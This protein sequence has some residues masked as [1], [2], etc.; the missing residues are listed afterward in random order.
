HLQRIQSTRR[1]V[2][3]IFHLTENSHLFRV[4]TVPLLPHVEGS[5]QWPEKAQG[6]HQS[7]GLCFLLPLVNCSM[8]SI[9]PVPLARGSRSKWSKLQL[10]RFHLLRLRRDN[11]PSVGAINSSEGFSFSN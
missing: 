4:G 2:S 3:D 9:S 1:D 6:G 10:S 5:G 11:L 7:S 8:G